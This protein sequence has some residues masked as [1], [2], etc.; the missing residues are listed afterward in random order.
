MVRVCR[1]HGEEKECIKDSGQ[2]ARKKRPLGRRT[3][4]L[5]YNIKMDVREIGWDDM[6]WI[7]LAQDREYWRSLVNMVINLRVP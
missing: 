1:T 6:E 5:E 4:K 2:K 7:H 3:H